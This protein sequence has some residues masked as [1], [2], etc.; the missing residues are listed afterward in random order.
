MMKMKNRANAHRII[1]IC[2][3]LIVAI[4]VNVTQIVLGTE[5]V[6]RAAAGANACIRESITMLK[7]SVT[8]SRSN[9]CSTNN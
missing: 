5:N 3:S 1:F 8:L 9:F 4:D 7:A 6:V 2:T